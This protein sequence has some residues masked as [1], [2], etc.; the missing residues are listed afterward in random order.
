M[1]SPIRNETNMCG[2]MLLLLLMMMVMLMMMKRTNEIVG[3][4]QALAT[5]TN[6]A[7]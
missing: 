2:S 4:C 1:P 5:E 6:F 3:R 7:I